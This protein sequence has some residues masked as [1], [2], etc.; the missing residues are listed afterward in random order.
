MQFLLSL[1]L[2][3]YLLCG[4][5]SWGTKLYPASIEKEALQKQ[6]GHAT[7]VDKTVLVAA[8]L[9]LIQ[10]TPSDNLIHLEPFR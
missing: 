8:T 9:G 3:L 4:Q 6:Y 5:T 1:L 10:H 7:D 2:P